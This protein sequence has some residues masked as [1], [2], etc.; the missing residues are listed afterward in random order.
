MP[1]WFVVA[2]CVLTGQAKSTVALL[3]FSAFFIGTAL[4]I[5][6]DQHNRQSNA[7]ERRGLD[8]LGGDD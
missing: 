7:R 5:V 8:L 2:Y 4:Y 1:A 3:A 6:F